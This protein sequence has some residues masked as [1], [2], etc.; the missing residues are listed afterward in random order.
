MKARQKQHTVKV[1]N[2]L[3]AGGIM[4]TVKPWLLPP[5]KV[6]RA[7][8]VLLVASTDDKGI[9]AIKGRSRPGTRR[10]SGQALP[11]AEQVRAHLRLN[12]VDYLASDVNLYRLDGAGVPQLIGAVTVAPTLL[13]YLGYCVVLDGGYAKSVDPQN[14]YAYNV[15]WD[16]GGFMYSA[17]D[18]TS[19]SNISLYSGSTTRAGIKITLPS[20]GPGSI[21][22]NSVR[23]MLSKTGAPTGNATA[24][25]YTADGSTL[26]ATSANLDVSTLATSALQQ[27]FAFASGA[28]RT[29][30]AQ[31]I[32]VIEY[33]GGDAS[34]KVNLHHATAT[35]GHAITYTSPNWS[36][37]DTAKEPLMAVGPG[38]APMALVGAG[39]NER[40]WLAGGG[41][42]NAEK[43]R[44]HYCY[45]LD[46]NNWGG[47]LYQGGSAGWIGVA[48]NDG[49][50]INGLARYYEELYVSKGGDNK[51][52]HAVTGSIPGESG[53]LAVKPIFSQEGAISGRTL[54]EVG[55]NLLFLETDA[56]L[57]V[58]S[59]PGGGFGNVR[60]FPR[61]TDVADVV[62]ENASEAAFA[63]YNRSHDQYWLQLAGLDYTLVYHELARS[64]TTYEW[65]GL[66]PTMFNH[67]DGQTFIG[68]GGHLFLLDESV[69]LDAYYGGTGQVFAA[70]LWGPMLD[71]GASYLD[72][73]FKWLAYQLSARLGAYGTLS[74]R[75]RSDA[76]RQT[77][78]DIIKDV[79]VPLDDDVTIGELTSLTVGQTAHYP[80]GGAATVL[81]AHP[82]NFNANY[83]QVR[84]SLEPG[85]APVFLGP[86]SLTVAILG[87]S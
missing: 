66:T 74:F 77:S 44:L 18:Q 54:A 67:Q 62:R 6:E 9:V 59:I 34:N 8:N 25:I 52:L 81:A 35:A 75:L 16:T 65:A 50:V 46:C 48:R 71:L 15:L 84:L 27:T 56:V 36:T 3:P 13:E 61:S 69:S 70:E 28:S 47:Q 12:S 5:N 57:A 63:V 87:R 76:G 37:V 26:L 7:V 78:L 42:N 86:V 33:S 10:I 40:L 72:K 43:S 60:K 80:V 82:L 39:K 38:L 31:V 83:C 24:K 32:V 53:D 58:E 41:A 68:S 19:A 29:A 1:V 49:G 30:G 21:A 55:N 85:G 14:A 22:L 11:N 51:S 4:T 45:A 64:W 23:A 73:E 20:W 79:L 2:F 17:L